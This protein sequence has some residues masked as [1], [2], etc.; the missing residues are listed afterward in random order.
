VPSTVL[1]L[2]V[3]PPVLLRR[4]PITAEQLAGTLESSAG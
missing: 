2:T 4:G 3:A 1:D